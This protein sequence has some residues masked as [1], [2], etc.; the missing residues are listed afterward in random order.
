KLGKEAPNLDVVSDAT[1][2]KRSHILYAFTE[3]QTGEVVYVGR[4][5]G[6][7]TPRQVLQD[8]LMKPHEHFD[9]KIH[10][11]VVVEVLP[12]KA[13]A[14]GAEEV[15]LVGLW[16]RGNKLINSPNDWGVSYDRASRAT[17]ALNRLQ[18]FADVL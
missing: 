6:E 8:R 18:G 4:A 14:H 16:E 15:Y 11:A 3:K 1:G 10:D 12:G 9:P 7:G 17:S 5:A 2:V 13:A